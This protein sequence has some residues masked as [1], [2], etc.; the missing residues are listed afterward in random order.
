[1]SSFK[2]IKLDTGL[3]K[4]LDSLLVERKA[5]IPPLARDNEPLQSTSHTEDTGH[6]D[7]APLGEEELD[8]SNRG[9]SAG[10]IGIRRVDI[11]ALLD[12]VAIHAEYDDKEPSSLL[13]LLHSNRA[14]LYQNETDIQ[15]FVM[16]VLEDALLAMGLKGFLEVRPEI[17]VFSYR[18]DIIVVTHSTRGIILVVEVKQ[19]GTDVF[20]S[21]S[22]AG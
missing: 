19:P 14:F 20:T 7:A 5:L 2:R 1:M 6:E 22:V 13:S 9:H 17:S 10:Q 21:H 15:R 11:P 3:N 18:P 16:P 12:G 8:E 4:T